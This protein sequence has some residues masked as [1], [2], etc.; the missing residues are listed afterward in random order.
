MY[1]VLEDQAYQ[2]YMVISYLTY[3]EYI[4]SGGK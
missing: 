2:V 3:K 1:I 4:N